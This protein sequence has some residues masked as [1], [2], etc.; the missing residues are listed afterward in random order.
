[1]SEVIDLRTRST[2]R[3]DCATLA[4]NKLLLARHSLG[5][6]QS[7]FANLLSSV[8][9][10]HVRPDALAAW[11]TATVPPG[12][13]LVAV[14]AVTPAATD[15][16]GIRSHKF[17]AS[18]AGTA[19]GRIGGAIA[20]EGRQLLAVPHPSGKCDLH[21]W[22]YGVAIFHLVEDLDLPNIANLAVWRYRSYQENLDWATAQLRQLADDDSITAA[23]VLSLYWLHSPTWVGGML[24]TALRI[25]CAPRVLVDRDKAG[26]NDC[27]AAAEQAEREL[28]AEGFE[29]HEMRSFGL[30][31]VSLG[32]ASWS[33]VTYHP[34]DPARCL[35]E[36]E[37]VAYELKMQ[38]IW[39]YCDHI[40][41]QVEQG[42]EPEIND[43]YGWRFL[44]AARSK[45]TNP[46]SQETGQHRSMREAVYET[47]GL[48]G[49]L[50]Q[51]IEVLREADMP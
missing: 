7:E 13:V 27:L 6:S 23:Y 5:L 36:T 28:L 42:R 47:S 35:T 3:P 46:R 32:Y 8:L 26:S 15:R 2:Y 14:S 45:L 24:D 10:W 41:G 49:H 40:N 29:H 33:G 11:E 19:A 31:G 30:A 38:T 43:G 50:H 18:Y 21:I 37:L 22:P 25:I 17:I 12:D 39:T 1:M 4:R 9:G 44:R 34:L 48:A 16:I 51:A 20:D